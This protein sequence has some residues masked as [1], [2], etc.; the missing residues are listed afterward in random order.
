MGELREGVA[1]CA[2]GLAAAG[3]AG[4]KRDAAL[5]LL[6]KRMEVWGGREGRCDVGAR[7]GA[8]G[9]GRWVGG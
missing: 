6:E 5:R 3:A 2:A 1:G 4:E 7:E 8:D 9:G